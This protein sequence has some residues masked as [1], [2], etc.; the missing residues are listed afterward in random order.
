MDVSEV[1][2]ADLGRRMAA[3][4]I[5]R[6]VYTDVSRDGMLTGPNVAA[7]AALARETGLGVIA[8]GGVSSLEDLE[9]LAAHEAE[10]IEGAIIGMALYTGRVALGEAL[11]GRREDGRRAVTHK[12]RPSRCWPNGS[13]PAWIS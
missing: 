3:L 11:A 4:G 5:R 2:A 10:G 7:T 12:E 9:R 8:S 6:V 1:E 13:S